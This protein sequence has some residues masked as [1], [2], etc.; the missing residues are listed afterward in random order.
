MK[1]AAEIGLGGKPDLW[2]IHNHC[3]GKNPSLT[4]AVS[5]LAE[6]GNPILLQPHDFAEDGR[7][8]NFNCLNQVY[9]KT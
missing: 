3:L 4:Q 7:P 9:S 8:S 1:K 5:H 2:H 6:D